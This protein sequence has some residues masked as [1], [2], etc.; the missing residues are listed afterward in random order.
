M[1]INQ[2]IYLAMTTLMLGSLPLQAVSHVEL[3][4]DVE[5]IRDSTVWKEKEGAPTLKITIQ[6]AYK[7][8]G[9]VEKLIVQLEGAVWSNGNGTNNTPYNGENIEASNIVIMSKGDM[10]IQFDVPIPSD[11][12]EGDEV[13]FCIP[14]LVDTRA[15]EVTVK[16]QAGEKSE[17]INEQVVLIG[18]TSNKKVSWQIKEIPTITEKGTIAEI[19]LTEIRPYSV[20]D[21]LEI[22]LKLQNPNIIFGDFNYIN[23][24]EHAD[25]TEYTV[26]P[27]DYVEYGGGFIGLND[28]VQIKKYNKEPQKITFK[29]KGKDS[30]TKGTMTLKNIPIIN[31]NSSIS[32]QDILLTIEGNN[33]VSPEQDVIVAYIK[34]STEEVIDEN[35]INKEEEE[36]TEEQIQGNEEHSE[37]TEKEIYFTV[38]ENKY[39][40]EDECFEMDA[41]AFIQEPGYIMVPLKYVALSLGLN[42]QDILFNGGMIYFKYGNRTIELQSGSNMAR[43]NKANLEMETPVVI[44]DGRSYAPMG[45]VAK[46]LGLTKKWDDQEKRAIFY[47]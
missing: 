2:K 35:Q 40:V 45:E 21:K 42:E 15:D 47:Q 30:Q 14:L 22:T 11:L 43:V 26:A 3:V 29:I 24:N 20:H 7:K 4:S 23:K 10:C 16:I 38:G 12:Q 6:D 36:N 34:S 28:T 39:V 44:V 31:Q 46:L 8:V 37:K 13:S 27:G 1:K 25:D 41:Q 9:K 32:E 5:Y 18:V 33:I 17:L 19:I